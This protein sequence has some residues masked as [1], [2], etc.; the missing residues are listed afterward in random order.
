MEAMRVTPSLP[1]KGRHP[2]GSIP[3]APV[4]TSLVSYACFD[5]KTKIDNENLVFQI[6]IFL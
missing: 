1:Q 5:S 2:K 3:L 6:P 4:N